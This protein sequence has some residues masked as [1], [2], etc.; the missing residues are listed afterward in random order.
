LVEYFIKYFIKYEL[1]KK[2]W[3]PWVLHEAAQHFQIIY[4]LVYPII[5]S[6]PLDTFI[7]F[8]S[9]NMCVFVGFL[10]YVEIQ[11][12]TG[13]HTEI[14][15][16]TLKMRRHIANNRRNI[17]KYDELWRKLT[18][19]NQIWCNTTKYNEMR[20]TIRNYYENLRNLVKLSDQKNGEV[21]QQVERFE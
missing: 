13:K 2:N 15:R 14:P 21:L 10:K 19:H 16:N 3:K 9:I 17:K 11:R 6:N 5:L 1:I 8:V 20:R 12:N 7:K 18:T 4:Q